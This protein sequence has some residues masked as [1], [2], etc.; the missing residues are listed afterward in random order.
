MI[1]KVLDWLGIGSQR[2]HDER[3]TAT[4]MPTAILMA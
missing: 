3:N 4:T 2:G 1:A